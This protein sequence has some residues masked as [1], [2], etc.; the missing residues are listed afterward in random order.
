M[1]ISLGEP[2]EE[3]RGFH[4]VASFEE[5]LKSSR[6]Q[7]CKYGEQVCCVFKGLSVGDFI[8]EFQCC[9]LRALAIPDHP[10][11]IVLARLI[12]AMLQYGWQG[13]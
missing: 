6:T 8:Q 1:L 10:T 13:P 7:V 5:P 12:H 2:E 11:Q 3:A 4:T 9:P